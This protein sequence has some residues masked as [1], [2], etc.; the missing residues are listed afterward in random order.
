MNLFEANKAKKEFEE[1]LAAAWAEQLAQL[2]TPPDSGDSSAEPHSQ[3]TTR[4]E[5][6][7]N[8]L[9]HKEVFVACTLNVGDRV[10]AMRNEHGNPASPHS[11]EQAS[12]K[13]TQKEE[14]Q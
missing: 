2:R 13:T 5:R 6:D 7:V 11:N 1:L 10:Y 9:R 12:Q 4:K 14:S 3:V 8:T